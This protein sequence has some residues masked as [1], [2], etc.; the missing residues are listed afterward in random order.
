MFPRKQG[1]YKMENYRNLLVL[2]PEHAGE[3]EEGWLDPGIDQ[4][5]RNHPPVGD[6]S[7]K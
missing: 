4:N 7:L 3:Y 6:M 5:Q 2:A 1:D